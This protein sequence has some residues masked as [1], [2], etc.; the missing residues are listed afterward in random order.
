[1]SLGMFPQL[2]SFS[3]VPKLH[4]Q[5]P[6]LHFIWMSMDT[7]NSVSLR[8]TPSSSL[9]TVRSPV[10]WIKVNDLTIHSI[11]KLKI[12]D[13]RLFLAISFLWIQDDSQIPGQKLIPQLQIYKS[14]WLL[15]SM[16]IW[17]TNRY[18][19]FTKSQTGF[20]IHP[21]HKIC[22]SYSV[23]RCMKYGRRRTQG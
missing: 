20:T 13:L 7:S 17:V 1:M 9:K 8:L 4:R 5:W 16:S 12:W 19:R 6:L 21:P 18:S 22:I 15:L 14:N 3:G 23:F 2:Q 10:F 11:T